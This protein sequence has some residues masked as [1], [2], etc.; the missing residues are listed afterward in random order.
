MRHVNN[1]TST[2]LP[3]CYLQHRLQ[4]FVARTVMHCASATTGTSRLGVFS[5]PISTLGEMAR[6]ALTSTVST[7]HLHSEGN[8]LG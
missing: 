8:L 1:A 6:A 5:G 3:W 4:V 7:S 2:I